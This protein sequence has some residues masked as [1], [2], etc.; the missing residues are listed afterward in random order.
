MRLA[1]EPL[2][3]E[4]RL[5]NRSRWEGW[6]KR[7]GWDS[8]GFTPDNTTL[9]AMSIGVKQ[10]NAAFQSQWPLPD[11]MHRNVGF[12]SLGTVLGYWSSLT[13]IGSATFPVASRI[14][15]SDISCLPGSVIGMQ[16]HFLTVLSFNNIVS[17]F[18]V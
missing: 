4:R 14:S 11:P 3:S 18:N 15:L 5:R 17:A 9:G 13:S 10:Y 8:Q 12:E 7:K 1:T 2:A 16:P 6:G